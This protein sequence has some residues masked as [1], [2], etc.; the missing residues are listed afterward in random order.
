M[1]T[2]SSTNYDQ[3]FALWVERTV[4]LLQAR[5]F[6]A[7]DWENLIEEIEGLTRSDKRELESRLTTLFEHALKRRYVPQPDCYRGWEG[8]LIRT[9]QKLER[10]LQDSPSLRNYLVGIIEVCYQNA[11]KN[12]RKEYD[13]AFPDVLPFTQNVQQLLSDEFWQ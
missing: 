7:V 11:L 13:A 2:G 10:I 12:M 4:S 3:D 5:D 9:Q 1:L 8:T 6:T